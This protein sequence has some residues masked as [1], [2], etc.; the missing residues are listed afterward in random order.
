MEA[1]FAWIE[2]TPLSIWMREDFYAYFIVLIFHSIGMG[3]LVGGGIAVSLRTIGFARGAALEK[4][5]GFFPVM[6]IGVAFASIS[7]VFLLIGYPAK[8]LTNPIFAFKF[9]CLIAAGLT[10]RE[11]ARRL[12]PIAA[13]GG[14]LPDNARWV[15]L[16]AAALWIGGI[17]GGKLL[18]YTYTVLTVS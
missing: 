4:F 13:S 2:Q 6:W 14:S 10:T 11:I 5:R 9:A 7:G 12:F 17:A 1:A 15:G 16:G 18:L 8:A 3:L